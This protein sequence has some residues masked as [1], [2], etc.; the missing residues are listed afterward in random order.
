MLSL[1]YKIDAFLFPLDAHYS[2]NN[3]QDKELSQMVERIEIMVKN[4]VESKHDVETF[5]NF[6]LDT[7]FDFRI[8]ALKW[9]TANKIIFTNIDEHVE[10]KLSYLKNDPQ[11]AVLYQNVLFAIRTNVR[12]VNSLIDPNMSR[13]SKAS[14]NFSDLNDIPK[15]SFTEFMNMVSL[16]M[17]DSISS[18]FIDWAISSLYIEFG[19]ISAFIINKEQLQISSP[20]IDELAAFIAD[21]AQNFG[22]ISKELKPQPIKET[23][24][25]PPNL[26]EVFLS[27]QEFL[28]EQDIEL[29]GNN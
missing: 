25:Y 24:T 15:Y 4:F 9:L 19:I 16:T 14:V 7:L 26:S 22:A 27:E 13:A 6:N 10:I 2:G 20:K 28:A 1:N 23:K 3:K 17:P 11:F 12:A 8:V 5:A 29:L 18:T 21:S